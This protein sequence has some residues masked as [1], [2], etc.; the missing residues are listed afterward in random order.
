MI[1]ELG[2]CTGIE[3]YSKHLSGRKTGEPPPT[4]FDY[5]PHDGL[6]VV[7][8]SHVTIPQIG[9]MYKGD[10]SRKE[11][12]VQYGFRLPSALDNRPLRFEEWE[13][14]VPQCIFVTAT[15]GRYE[16][17]KAGAIVEQLVRPTGLLDP[18][19][20]VRGA[21]TQ[22]DDLLSEINIRTAKGERILVTTLT[23]RM[24]EDLT[25]Y[26]QEHGVKVR[27]LHSD[28]DTV[29]RVEIIRDLRLGKFDV[30]VGINLLREGLDIPEVSLV[31]IL[32]ADK[33]GFLR[34]ETALIQTI[35][36]AARNVNGRAIL[37]ADRI[38]GSMKRAMDETD[39]RRLIQEAH[40]KEH[41]ITP[42]GIKKGVTDI[43]EGA[44]AGS[45]KSKRGTGRKVAEPTVA[46]YADTA[47][48][49][50]P[51]A[52]S[53]KIK[54]LEMVMYKHSRDLEFEEAGRVRDQLTIL[55]RKAFIG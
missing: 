6:V 44:Y 40:N 48:D 8:E 27:Y 41:G 45:S 7:D 14:L 42:E 16:G 37:Y 47:E 35:G 28:I 15:P 43:M 19:I 22:V 26:L 17:E 32:D 55:K 1:R 5:L 52:L 18:I 31:A 4:L 12:L 50:S 2:F 10:R 36:R 11:N 3:N 39:R 25:D 20:E 24:S 53:N 49:L 13:N 33:E 46:S 34:S 21:T 30:L 38:T 23:K 54:E 29:E 9:A 51:K